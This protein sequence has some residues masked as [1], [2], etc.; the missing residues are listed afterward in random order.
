MDLDAGMVLV[1]EQRTG[2][3]RSIARSGRAA[4][5]LDSFCKH[6]ST[7]LATMA[8]R[9]TAN[10]E[11]LLI[12]AVAYAEA[13]T[14]DQQPAMGSYD[15]MAIPLTV[16]RTS[17]GVLL[18]GNQCPPGI[19]EEDIRLFA[20]IGQ[21]IDLALKN[22]QFMRS[23]SEM[24]A[25][26]EADRLKSEFLAAVSHDLRSPL[27][28]I[29]TSVESLLDSSGVQS[30]MEQQHL[31]HNI[32]DQASGLERLVDH[33]LDFSRIEAGALALD[34]DWTELSV[35]IADT[36]SKFERLRHGSQVE[37]DLPADLP[38]CYADPDRLVQVLWNLLEN[39]YKYAPPL[40]PIRVEARCAGAEML[41][42]IADRGA[43]IPA[44]EHEK[45]FQR[46]YRLSHHQRSP[47]K[48]SGLGLAICRGIVEAHGG[49]IWVEDRAGGGSIFRVAMPLPSEEL[50]IGGASTKER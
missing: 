1:F 14:P 18:V 45:V 41:I 20:T 4:M 39:A 3:P 49:R 5:L 24:D 19:T 34:C 26:R 38:I 15:V 37:C 25:L 28:A 32:A 22:A 30:A 17:P 10:Y 6:H 13:E 2:A 8:N 12:P 42:S 27:T 47:A 29:R 11:P 33:L 36:V 50:E 16:N 31:M 40:S 44:E 43:G 9:V 7:M 46:F 21:Q 35:L 48:G 23:A